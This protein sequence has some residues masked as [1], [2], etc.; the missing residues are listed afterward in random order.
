MIYLDN[1]ATTKV[2]DRVLQEMLPYFTEDYGNPSSVYSFSRKSADAVEHTREVIAQAINA[3]PEE[4][5]FTSGASEANNWILRKV[6][7]L[8][9]ERLATST[10]EHHSVLNTCKDLEKHGCSVYYI[11][12]NENGVVSKDEIEETVY[13]Y[14]PDCVSIMTANNEIGTI[15]SLIEIGELLDRKNIFFHTDATQAFGHIPID[16]Q[17]NKIDFLSASAHKFGGP[18]GVGFAYIGKGYNIGP[19][20]DGGS[21]ERNKRAGTLNV[22][23]IVG[24]GKAVEICM[25]EMFLRIEREVNMRD[26]LIDRVL[27]EIPNSKLNGGREKRLPNNANFCFE[28]VSGEALLMML[29]GAGICVSSGSACTAGNGEPSHVLKAI[30]LS[31]EQARNS[32]RITL[33]HENTLKEIDYVVDKLKQFVE[34]LRGL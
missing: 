24:M 7:E 23:G 5:Y 22:P 29:D 8:V 6:V 31:D 32:I 4:I 1:A 17:D 18:K 34:R 14:D 15:Q 2:D 33:S 13:A 30:G 12:V 20:I 27:N 25:D 28:G 11:N 10:I 16:V 21:Q 19:L 26:H 3:K 9:G